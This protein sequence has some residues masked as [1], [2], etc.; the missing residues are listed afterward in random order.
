MEELPGASLEVR[1]AEG[2]LVESWISDY[3][4]H[5]L[6]LPAGTYTL[7]E[8]AAPAKY[9]KAE[10]ITFEVTDTLEV[11]TVE[12]VDA[13][14]QVLI[15]KQDIT[16]QKELP[17][18]QLMV[19]DASGNIIESWIS[20]SEPHLMNLAVGIY[21][22]TE[23]TAP[24]G[25]AKAETITFEVTDTAELQKVTMYDKPEEPETETES[26]S[27]FES[28]S[29]TETELE[30]E[31]DTE[32]ETQEETET[33]PSSEDKTPKE[34]E[35]EKNKENPPTIVQT[36]DVNRIL[37]SVLLIAAGLLLLLSTVHS[38][39]KQHDSLKK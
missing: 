38:K 2:E 13:P 34:T 35:T 19:T 29:E 32:A 23:V 26:E 24:N 22:L 30:T 21:T 10:T 28:E 6:N 8:V 7:T 11:Q 25:Y 15:S 12:M 33:E 14:I 9:A 16:T 27:E 18:A 4:P 39:K 37:P 1:T 3:K 17:G 5:Y 20:S 36:G 31:T